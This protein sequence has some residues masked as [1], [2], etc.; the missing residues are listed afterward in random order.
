MTRA[1]R[2]YARARRLMRRCRRQRRRPHRV[3]R[4]PR[5]QPAAPALVVRAVAEVDVAAARRAYYRGGD[6]GYYFELYVD[7]V[8]PDTV[9][10]ANTNLEWSRDG[11]KTFS[12][13]PN[14]AATACT[15][16]SMRSGPTPRIKQPHRHRQR[17]RLV[18]IVGRRQDVAAFLESAGHAVLSREHRQ[19]AAVLSRV[20]RRA[21]QRIDVRAEPHAG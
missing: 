19:R 15:S 18:R 14:L 9:W 13:V 10:S 1:P 16:T 7:P 11:G 3:R 5:L 4:L 12:G 20:R 17:R 21:G 8:R 6:P 2:G